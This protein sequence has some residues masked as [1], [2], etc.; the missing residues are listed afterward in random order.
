M[1]ALPQSQYRMVV[2]ACQITAHVVNPNHNPK[3]YSTC[4]HLTLSA[5]SVESMKNSRWLL[6]AAGRGATPW[7]KSVEVVSPSKQVLFMER[8]LFGFQVRKRQVKHVSTARL[9]LEQWEMLLE[10]SCLLQQILDDMEAATADDGTK[11][12]QPA[13]L[14]KARRRAVEGYFGK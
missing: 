8:V 7:W 11:L 9:S 4:V 13:D 2:E 14:A 6:G 10:T 3:S 5:F 1:H 12:F